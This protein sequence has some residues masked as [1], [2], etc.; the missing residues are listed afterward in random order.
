M[1]SKKLFWGLVVF[2]ILNFAAHLAFYPALPD[3]I[4]IHWG[5]NGEVNGW[6]PKW[7]VLITA[8]LP[9]GLLILFR[10]LPVIDPKADNYKRFRPIWNGFILGFTLFMTAVGWLSELSVFGVLPDESNLV[11]IL[12]GGG[13]GILF[14]L[15]GNY[16]PR[17]KQNYTFGCRTPWAL[18]NEHN[19]NRTQRM[20]GFTFIGMG[21]LVLLSCVFAG[22]LGD[23]GVLIVLLVATLGGSVWIYLYSFLVYKGWMK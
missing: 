13:I 4:P 1:M 5:A 20:G 18:D 10:I 17:I 11:G 7:S 21:I 15:L 6:G 23:F 2:L 3:T 22:I 8:L 12:V 14:I 19:W 9:A 16:M